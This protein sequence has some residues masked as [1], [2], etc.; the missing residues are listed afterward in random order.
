V[1]FRPR[2]VCSAGARQSNVFAVL[3][4]GS[5]DKSGDGRNRPGHDGSV[6]VIEVSDR[7]NP[8]ALH[9]HGRPEG[10]PAARFSIR[11]SA[12]PCFL[13]HF[14][15]GLQ[16]HNTAEGFAPA[17]GSLSSFR[18]DLMSQSGGTTRR[19]MHLIRDDA[20]IILV[21][22]Q[23]AGTYCHLENSTPRRCRCPRTTARLSFFFFFEVVGRRNRQ[24]PS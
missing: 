11:D 8:T 22:E 7:R 9:Q 14:R 17:S 19:M 18:S 23:P 24:R 4:P 13:A 20:P 1:S 6:L 12:E 3:S 16:G 5:Q 2:N 21:L 15:V 10:P